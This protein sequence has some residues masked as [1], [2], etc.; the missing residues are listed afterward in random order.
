MSRS[1]LVVMLVEEGADSM[2][3]V[4]VS[5]GGGR[6]VDRGLVCSLLLRGITSFGSNTIV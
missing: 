6:L 3:A 4:E 5:I 2:N 1:A